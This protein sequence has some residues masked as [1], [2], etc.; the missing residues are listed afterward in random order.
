MIKLIDKKYNELEEN[1]RNRY[2]SYIKELRGSILQDSFNEE[3][4]R[5]QLKLIDNENREIRILFIKEIYELE[6]V[7]NRDQKDNFRNY[8]N[9]IYTRKGKF[10]LP[11][12]MF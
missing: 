8:L 4:L 6:G 10:A 11:W 12:N 9:K 7:L 1:Y 2:N 3:K 5:E